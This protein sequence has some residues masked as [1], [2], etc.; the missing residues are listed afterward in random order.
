M[1]AESHSEATASARLETT[2]AQERSSPP[3]FAQLALIARWFEQRGMLAGIRD[4]LHITRRVDATAGLDV[5]LALLAALI[6]QRSIASAVDALVPMR[7]ALP[8][9]WA[10]KSM[11]SRSAISRFLAALTTHE[12]DNMQSLFCPPFVS[13]ASAI[14]ALE[15]S[16]IGLISDS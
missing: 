10:R 8:S 13:T 16:P 2:S 11:P 5:V 14:S 1:S 15:D 12:L 4:A 3:W 6:G 9:L 7:A